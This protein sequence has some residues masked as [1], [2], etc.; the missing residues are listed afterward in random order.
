MAPSLAVPEEVA[1]DHLSS[2]QT[3]PSLESV[4]REHFRT[5]WRVLRRLGVSPALLDDATQDVFLVVQ[6]KLGDVEPG[7]RV[8]SW[9]LAI[10]VR[11]AC[12]Y[13]RR[14]GRQRAEPLDDGI[15]D[16]RPGPA[17]LS[18]MQEAIRTLEELLAELDEK[19]RVV[20]VLS[21]LEELSVPEIAGALGAN[22]NTV[23]SRLRSAKKQFDA[24]LARRR[25]SS[26]QGARR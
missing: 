1:G 25:A 13:R 24:A 10:A 14:A 5:V 8:K 26:R 11:V 2:T 7:S 3:P 18:E 19:R 17:R 15:I 21:E 16:A 9:V 23:Y 4:Y 22:S 6:R 12:E 20:F